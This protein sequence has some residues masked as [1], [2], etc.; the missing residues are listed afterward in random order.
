MQATLNIIRYKSWGVPFAFLSMA[1]FHIPMMFNKKILFY[2]LMGSGKNGTFD[3][4]PDVKQWAILSVHQEEQA[5]VFTQKSIKD[6]YGSFISFWLYLFRCEVFT[7]FLKPMEGHGLWDKKEVFGK[8][9]SNPNHTGPIATLTRATIRLNTL[10]YF[11]KNV[12]PVASQMSS[13]KGF[14]TSFG[15]G[16]IPWIKQA[17]FSIWES[18]DDMKNFAYRMKA[19]AEVIKKTRAQK[20]YSEDMFVRF[21]IIG[22]K[23]TIKGINPLQNHI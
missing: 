13:S 15:I 10:S 14:I 2:K 16:E 21:S 18:R 20:W 4:V 17:T 11:W 19:H 23:G 22:H 5:D 6:F 12:A 8:L 9:T 1:V 3:K 7:I